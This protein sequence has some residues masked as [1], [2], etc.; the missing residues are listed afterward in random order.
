MSSTTIAAAS[1]PAAYV[2]MISQYPHTNSDD[3]YADTLLIESTLNQPVELKAYDQDKLKYV[4]F[5]IS[6]T[7]A[8]LPLPLLVRHKFVGIKYTGSAPTTGSITL[9][10]IASGLA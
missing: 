6:T 7:S 5:A 3:T 10:S 1:V 8:A 2:P 4:T 9:T